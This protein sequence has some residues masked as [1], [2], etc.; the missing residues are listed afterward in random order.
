MNDVKEFLRT[1]WIKGI[2][3]V[4]HNY[5]LVKITKPFTLKN[6][7]LDK[8]GQN[9]RLQQCL[10]TIEAHM[11]MRGLHERPSRGHFATKIT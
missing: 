8:M 4:Q 5:I 9:N 1:R 7:E 11:S 6:G 2:L 3:S 10:T